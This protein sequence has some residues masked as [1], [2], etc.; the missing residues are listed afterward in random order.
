M[1]DKRE[2]AW[3]GFLIALVTAGYGTTFGY[4]VGDI[5]LFVAAV[6]F[7]DYRAAKRAGRC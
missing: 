4:I 2:I 7:I 3:R 6:D 1:K 5:W